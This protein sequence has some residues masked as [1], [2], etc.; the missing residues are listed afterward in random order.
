MICAGC[1]FLLS[2]L[3][4]KAKEPEI[5]HAR[6]GQHELFI[7]KAYVGFRHTSVGNESALLV[8]WYPGSDIPP[9][10]NG[11]ELLRQGIWWKHV[12]ILI[13]A[14]SA[15]LDFDTVAKKSIDHLKATE[16]AG[17]EYGLAHYEQKSIP[18]NDKRDVW[19]ELKEGKITAYI[20]CSD[21]IGGPPVPHCSLYQSIGPLRFE[22]SFNR[23][24]L[25]EW[26]TIRQNILEMIESFWSEESSINYVSERL[27]AAEN[28][29]GK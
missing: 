10:N 16:F 13:T 14:N 4:F 28:S 6:L 5:I 8:T 17:N 21:V 26:S 18:K 24:L 1:F 12:Q 20:T 7:P 25:P 19:F 27:K 3:P 11:G 15:S 9:G 2:C 29:S 23:R 22:A